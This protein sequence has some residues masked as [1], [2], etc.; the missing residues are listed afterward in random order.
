MPIH[1]WVRAGEAWYHDFQLGWAV[2][3]CRR[4]NHGV[5]PP[6]LYAMSETIDL[7][8]PAEFTPFPEPDGPER[9]TRW[10]HLLTSADDR[11]PQTRFR[12]VGN[13]RQYAT[14]I[15]SVRD[16]LHQPLAAVVWA[17]RQDRE[18]PHRWDALTAFVAGAVTRGVHA[19]VVDVFPPLPANSE[20]VHA[21]VWGRI[22][23]GSFDVPADKPLTF[24]SYSAGTE[25]SAYVEPVAVGDPVP[26]MPLFLTHDSY[27][28]CPLA[29][30]YDDEWKDFATFL[31]ERLDGP[32]AG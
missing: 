22:L 6:P 17:T 18:T 3:L 2:A 12:F 13:R 19:L 21:A 30:S 20:N 16:D 8:P 25:V 28:L 1:D 15:A 31:K 10:R 26:D 29:A 24:A 23:T 5:L 32:S 4:L 14:V 11:P 9:R 7:R 27:I